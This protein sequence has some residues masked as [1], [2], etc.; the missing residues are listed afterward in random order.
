MAGV[1]SLLETQQRQALAVLPCH[2]S[3]PR[4]ARIV[5]AFE[6][7]AGMKP[8]RH[9]RLALGVIDVLDVAVDS[10]ATHPLAVPNLTRVLVVAPIERVINR[11]TRDPARQA[12]ADG[13]GEEGSE[14]QKPIA[15]NATSVVVS[16]V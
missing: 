9:I 15:R 5:D 11:P 3:A 1:G 10:G 2:L 16:A 8:D 4:T 13:R 14:R 6:L 12:A 7:A